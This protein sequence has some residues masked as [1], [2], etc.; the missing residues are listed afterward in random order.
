MAIQSFGDT[1]LEE[2]FN[3]GTIRKRVSW[4]NLRKIVMRKLDML[5]YASVLE[6]L[7]SPPGNRLELLRGELKGW[8]SIRIN[9]QWRIIFEWT[10][11]GPQKVK[12][13]DYHR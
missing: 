6:D 8:Y 1:V 4:K 12:V 11:N 5:H 7:K 3:T 13:R 10:T 2:F 9:D